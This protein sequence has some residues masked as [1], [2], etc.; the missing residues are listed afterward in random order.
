M[1]APE[2][3]I[4]AI[5][6]GASS[7]SFSAA[8]PDAFDFQCEQNPVYREFLDLTGRKNLRISS[9]KEIPFLPVS[10]F[11]SRE[12]V[13]GNH[14]PQAVF[15]SSTTTGNI[16]SKHFIADLSLYRRSLTESFRFAFGDPAGYAYLALLPSY[17]ERKDSSLVF[18][19]ETLMEHSRHELNGFYLDDYD[20]LSGSLRYATENGVS[21]LFLGVTFALTDFAVSNPGHLGNSIV[22]METGGMKGKSKDIPRSELHRMLGDAFGKKDI[23]GEYGMTEMLSQCYSLSGG[24]YVPPPWARVFARDLQDPLRILDNGKPGGINIIDLANIFS[25]PFLATDDIG[26]VYPDGT[27]EITGRITGSE[28]RGCNLMV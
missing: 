2:S 27:F 22:V 10:F 4:R 15:Y 23:A 17:L 24:R 18:M 13:A 11:K 21:C 26:R 12:I 25:C 19:M 14:N 6:S 8:L 1:T 28:A 9:E 20:R 7:D 3:V 16:P 5:D